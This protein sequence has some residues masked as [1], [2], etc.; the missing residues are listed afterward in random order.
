[1]T[2]YP[3]LLWDQTSLHPT[4]VPS[5]HPGQTRDIADAKVRS[6]V[7]C[8]QGTYSAKLSARGDDE[9]SE[10]SEMSE[11]SL[12][13]FEASDTAF[14][15]MPSFFMRVMNVVRLSPR[16][17]AAPSGPPTRPFASLRARIIWSRSTSL[18]MLRTGW[19]LADRAG[20]SSRAGSGVE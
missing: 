15:S 2:E 5:G 4:C 6:I 12:L 13:A 10:L 20:A 16:R 8:L 3:S 14:G 17:E 9:V 11:V 18:R 7:F 1:M 19:R